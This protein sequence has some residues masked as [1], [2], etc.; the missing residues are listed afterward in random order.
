MSGKIYVG[1]HTS[2]KKKDNYYGCGIYSNIYNKDSVYVKRNLKRSPFWRAVSKYGISE[3]KR[4]NLMYFQDRE[5]LIEAERFLVDRDFVNKSWNYNGSLGGSLPPC[6]KGEK[7]GN[8]GNFWTDEQKRSLSERLKGKKE[9]QRGNNN[10]AVKCVCVDLNNLKVHFF[11]CLKDLS[12][13]I[14]VKRSTIYTWM[15]SN[16]KK[17]R[18]KRYILFFKKDWLELTD[19]EKAQIYIESIDNSRLNS[20]LN[21]KYSNN[22]KNQKYK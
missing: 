12:E 4:F 17:V 21:F 22:V 6:N 20:S 15:S 13:F 19:L 2:D 1:I 16:E 7:N 18:R 9:R 3:F 11:D 10:K 8:Y 5:S 14:Q